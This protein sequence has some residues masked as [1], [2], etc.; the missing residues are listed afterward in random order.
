MEVNNS[1]QNSFNDI[2]K[3]NNE[4]KISFKN[5]IKIYK[6]GTRDI[7]TNGVIA[8]LYTALTYA[9]FFL[10]YGFLFNP[11]GVKFWGLIPLKSIFFKLKNRS[12][13][14]GKYNL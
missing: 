5:Y 14:Y 2:N 4:T 9:F 11:I 10:S 1:T 13:F 12:F 3:T 8:A 6:L 7:A